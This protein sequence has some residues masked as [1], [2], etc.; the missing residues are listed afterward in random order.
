MSVTAVKH[1]KYDNRFRKS[2][3][4]IGCFVHDDSFVMVVKDFRF[5]LC[6]LL[7]SKKNCL[8]CNVRDAGIAHII[9]LGYN[10]YA[11]AFCYKHN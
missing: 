10:N 1:A 4:L 7:N 6:K 9:L 2:I 5:T 3:K 11:L 8:K